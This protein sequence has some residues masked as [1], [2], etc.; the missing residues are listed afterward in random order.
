LTMGAAIPQLQ[1]PRVKQIPLGYIKEEEKKA[2]VYSA[3]NLLV[4]AAL[5]ENFPNVVLESIACGTPVVAF[6]AGGVGE[7]VRQNVTGWLVQQISPDPLRSAIESAFSSG[8]DLRESCRQIAEK[9]LSDELQARRYLAIR[10]E[11]FDQK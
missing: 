3:A 4:H 11:S 7:M 8:L 6:A 1:N 2:V 5:A 9:E 10:N